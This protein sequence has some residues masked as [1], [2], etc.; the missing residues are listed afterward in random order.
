[1]TPTRQQIEKAY[2]TY[3]ADPQ[4]GP[5]LKYMYELAIKEIDKLP[6]QTGEI[7]V[8]KT[9]DLEI[10]VS[11]EAGK[12]LDCFAGMVIGGNIKE[13]GIYSTKWTTAKFTRKT[14]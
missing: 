12:S 4:H 14:L 13:L 6:F 9:D 10:M 7:V 5:V 3:S 1:M 8:S 2:L 11:E